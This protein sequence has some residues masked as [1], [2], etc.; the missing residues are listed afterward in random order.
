[1]MD[2]DSF[3][4]KVDNDTLTIKEAFEFPLHCTQGASQDSPTVFG[5]LAT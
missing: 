2:I 5:F 1:M 3:V 4:E